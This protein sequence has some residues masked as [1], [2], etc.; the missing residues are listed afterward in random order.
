MKLIGAFSRERG[1]AAHTLYSFD[2]E[3]TLAVIF[4]SADE[5]YPAEPSLRKLK[6]FAVAESQ[7]RSRFFA[8]NDADLYGTSH[9]SIDMNSDED[10]LADLDELF[11]ENTHS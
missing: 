11:P 4:H 8:N 1:I 10:W 9:G 3:K 7:T 6:I 5:V 2:E